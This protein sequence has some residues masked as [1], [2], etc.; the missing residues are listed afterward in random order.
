MAWCLGCKTATRLFGA[1]LLYGATCSW[2]TWLF[3]HHLRALKAVPV[4]CSMPTV[5][6]IALPMRACEQYMI[7]YLITN[8]LRLKL[9]HFRTIIFCR[10]GLMWWSRLCLFVPLMPYLTFVPVGVIYCDADDSTCLFT[11]LLTYRCVCV[12]YA[13]RLVHYSGMTMYADSDLFDVCRHSTPYILWLTN[14]AL[15]RAAMILCSDDSTCWPLIPFQGVIHGT[16]CDIPFDA[17]LIPDI[18][19]LPFNVLL[20][21]ILCHSLH[22]PVCYISGTILRVFCLT[23]RFIPTVLRRALLPYHEVPCDL[24]CSFSVHILYCTP[25]LNTVTLLFDNAIAILPS[26]SFFISIDDY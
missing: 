14:R 18:T 24:I 10:V 23:A 21:F 5:P 1:I 8:R 13:M 22:L 2:A 17:F 11:C 26:H 15:C 7:L 6:T 9:L 19:L 16:R 3:I 12:M 25:M 20:Q 4:Q